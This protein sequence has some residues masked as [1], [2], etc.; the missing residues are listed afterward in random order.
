ME[1]LVPL[2]RFALHAQTYFSVEQ[3][4]HTAYRASGYLEKLLE[5]GVV[6]PQESKTLND[7]YE[8]AERKGEPVLI[9]KAAITKVVKDFSL[10]GSAEGD[11]VRA[12]EQARQRT[13]L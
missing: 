8:A 11:M 1:S 13:V 6:A 3:F 5:S 9:D 4:F 10:S 12:V 2:P 7:I